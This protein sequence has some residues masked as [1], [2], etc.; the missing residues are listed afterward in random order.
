LYG[1][2]DANDFI[3]HFKSKHLEFYERYRDLVQRI[4][5]RKGSVEGVGKD[6][7]EVQRMIR[8]IYGMGDEAL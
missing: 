5:F 3:A 1:R 7:W 4:S 8:D 2:F 6:M